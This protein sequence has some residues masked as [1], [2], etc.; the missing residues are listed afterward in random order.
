MVS[1]SFQS[2]II[3]LSLLVIEFFCHFNRIIPTIRRK[4]RNYRIQ[5][6]P[7]IEAQRGDDPFRRS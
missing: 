4:F 7:L 1:I 6:F 3:V 2:S 5:L